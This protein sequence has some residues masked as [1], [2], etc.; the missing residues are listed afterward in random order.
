[1]AMFW[2]H[3]QGPVAPIERRVVIVVII[4]NLNE[5]SSRV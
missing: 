1:M 3:A 5:N 2:P 4:C